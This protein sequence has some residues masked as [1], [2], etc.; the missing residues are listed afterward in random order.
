MYDFFSDDYQ[1]RRIQ[2]NL[3]RDRAIT[4]R[5]T[6]EEKLAFLKKYGIVDENGNVN[7]GYEFL[8]RDDN[9]D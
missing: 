4:A 5:R 3:D 9:N 7:P 1:I 8:W 6:P 2:A